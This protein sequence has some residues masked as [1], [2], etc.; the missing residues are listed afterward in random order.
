MA[1]WDP[2]A[3]HEAVFPGL[4]NSRTA[5]AVQP[6]GVGDGAGSTEPYT[7]RIT[8]GQG[9]LGGGIFL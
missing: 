2:S 1:S 6:A 4:C 7:D 8:A 3:R 5:W 9:W